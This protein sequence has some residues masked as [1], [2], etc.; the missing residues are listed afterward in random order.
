VSVRGGGQ[1]KYTNHFDNPNTAPDIGGAGA[2][3]KVE[4][5]TDPTTGKKAYRSTGE[6]RSTYTNTNWINDAVK[7][8]DK[9]RGDY[10]W[11]I[12]LGQDGADISLALGA[13]GRNSHAL[14]DFYA[15][16]NWVDNRERGG[17]WVKAS[18]KQ[19]KER[20]WVPRGL[21]K[22]TLWEEGFDSDVPIDS[23]FS[24]TVGTIAEVKVQTANKSTHAY[25]GKDTDTVRTD[26]KPYTTA[27]DS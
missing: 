17:C 11:V 12:D 26:E 4:E 27:Y 3:Y 15:H 24:G 13:F 7:A 8:V 18:D 25:W 1:C 2:P 21:D 16:S 14:A 23:L 19:I 22:R 6:F 20:G 10:G 9:E 5:Y